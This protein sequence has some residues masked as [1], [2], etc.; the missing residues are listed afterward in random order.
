MLKVSKR[1]FFVAV[2]LVVEN[3]QNET[4]VLMQNYCSFFIEQNVTKMFLNRIILDKK[5]PKIH[6]YVELN[7]FIFSLALNIFRNLIETLWRICPTT[8]SLLLK[9]EPIEINQK[10]KFLVED[11]DV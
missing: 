7:I 2:V 11:I 5:K 8:V 4:K 6:Q 10:F 1:R 3:V 9:S